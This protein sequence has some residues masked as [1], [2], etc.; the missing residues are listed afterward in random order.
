[1]AKVEPRLPPASETGPVA[2]LLQRRVVRLRCVTERLRRVLPLAARCLSERGCRNPFG[3][4]KAARL[5]DDGPSG[6][7]PANTMRPQSRAYWEVASPR[8]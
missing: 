6:Q 1:M 4:E 7:G 5:A 3:T 8:A 2:G